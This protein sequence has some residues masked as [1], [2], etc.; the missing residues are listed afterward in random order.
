MNLLCGSCAWLVMMPSIW[1][2]EPQQRQLLLTYLDWGLGRSP[3]LNKANLI[4]TLMANLQWKVEEVP[5][6]IQ[7][8]ALFLIRLLGLVTCFQ[9]LFSSERW[10]LSSV[11][12]SRPKGGTVTFFFIMLLIC[13]MGSLRSEVALCSVHTCM[14]Q[15]VR[16]SWFCPC[17][18]V[19]THQICPCANVITHQRVTQLFHSIPPLSTC[20]FS[21]NHTQA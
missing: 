6:L 8:K 4:C 5:L 2:K 19:I 12:P 14:N 10:F 17:T 16:L 13:N 1:Q 11:A 9:A 15:C 18:N 20:I 3:V 21:P 7:C